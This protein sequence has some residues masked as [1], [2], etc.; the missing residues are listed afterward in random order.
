VVDEITAYGILDVTIS[1]TVMLEITS[2]GM[3]VVSSSI[4]VVGAA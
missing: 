2:Y 3:L 1:I 4:I